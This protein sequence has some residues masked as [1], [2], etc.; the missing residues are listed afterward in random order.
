MADP[1]AD[2]HPGTSH[3]ARYFAY[4]HL[5]EQLQSV[6]RPFQELADQMIQALPDGPELTAGLRKLL[7]A[8][9]CMVR[10]AVDTQRGD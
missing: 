4:A 2:R 3:V 1:Y 7:E 5:P 9:D 8:K 6:S 10:A